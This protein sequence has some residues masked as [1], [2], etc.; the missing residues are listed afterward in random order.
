[1]GVAVFPDGRVVSASDDKM[2][3]VW[4]EPQIMQLQVPHNAYMGMH[5]QVQ[6]PDGRTI[7]VPIPAGAMPGQTIQVMV[8]PELER[9]T[10]KSLKKE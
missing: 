4:W 1:M 5:I 9:I 8:P 3:K 10:R 7:D 2:L 6:I